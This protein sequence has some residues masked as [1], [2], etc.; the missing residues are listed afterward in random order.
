MSTMQLVNGKKIPVPEWVDAEKLHRAIS[1]PLPPMSRVEA[2]ELEFDH[3]DA[4][5][6][7]RNESDLVIQF[8]RATPS[9]DLF[10]QVLEVAIQD[11]FK[12]VS[13]V[14][15]DK[16]L[17]RDGIYGLIFRGVRGRA[18]YSER[19]YSDT[20]LVLLNAMLQ[21]LSSC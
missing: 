9:A 15:L 10:E 19:Q 2:E 12:T 11:V 16:R 3:F 14:E 5:I 18:L 4:Y 7:P 6:M 1:A 17:A 20:F 8:T 13:G 21:E